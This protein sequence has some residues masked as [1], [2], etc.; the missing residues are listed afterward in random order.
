MTDIYKRGTTRWFERL[1]LARVPRPVV[2]I[3][4]T[5]CVN[6]MHKSYLEML[7][8]GVCIYMFPDDV[9][10]RIFI[11]RLR[12]AVNLEFQHQCIGGAGC[13]RMMLFMALCAA[14]WPR[15]PRLAGIQVSLLSPSP[16]CSFVSLGLSTYAQRSLKVSAESAKGPCTSHR[17]P[18]GELWKLI[19]PGSIGWF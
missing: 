19:G 6:I 3:C 18:A 17:Q 10:T 12:G 16:A 13:C 1:V 11:R 14:T 5:A 4:Y 15:S 8:R 9:C 7:D 2:Y